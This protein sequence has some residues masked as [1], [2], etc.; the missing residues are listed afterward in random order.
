MLGGEYSVVVV[1]DDCSQALHIANMVERS[2]C[3]SAL[4]SVKVMAPRELEGA[5]TQGASVDI[6]L[7]DIKLGEGEEDGIGYVKRCLSERCDTTQV[8]YVTGYADEYHM[9]VYGTQHVYLLEK[10]IA[11][12]NLDDALEAACTRLKEQSFRPVL[13]K[14]G[15]EGFIVRP[16]D[17][18]Y[19]ESVKRKVRIVQRGKTVEAYAK[20]EDVKRLLPSSFVRCHK[21]FLVNMAWI[22]HIEKG[23]ITLH[24]GS[25][26]P[27]SQRHR[28]EVRRALARYARSLL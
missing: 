25:M 22:E 20:I 17:V 5:M 27:V 4:C 6:L 8:V 3:A 2:A 24:D 7:I 1:D 21:S 10:P 9:S 11:Q 13:L 15:R 19:I 23:C 18:L 28:A 14:V 16:S 26:V 12:R